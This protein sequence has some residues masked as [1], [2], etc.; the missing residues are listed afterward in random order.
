MIYRFLR[1]RVRMVGIKLPQEYAGLFPRILCAANPGNIG[2]LFVKRT[3]ID[4]AHPFEIRRMPQSE[5]GMLRQY[6]PAR[7][8][9]NPSMVGDDPGYEARLQGLG[10]RRRPPCARR[11]GCGGGSLLFECEQRAPCRC[12]VCRPFAWLR[13]RLADWGSASPFSIG[14]WAVVSDD[15]TLDRDGQSILLPRA[16]S[17]AIAKTTAQA[18][19][20]AG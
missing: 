8:E 12:A 20:T 13:F 16:L 19:L 7:L 4:G 1:N 10:R 3:F 6:I 11:L 14:W 17:F 5:G 9:D 15:Y 18:V 2:H